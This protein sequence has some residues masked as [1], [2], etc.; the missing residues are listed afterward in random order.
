MILNVMT[1]DGKTAAINPTKDL[2]AVM[3]HPSLTDL[4]NKVNALMKKNGVKMCLPLELV[5]ALISGD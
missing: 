2:L 1:M 5:K 3:N 4:R